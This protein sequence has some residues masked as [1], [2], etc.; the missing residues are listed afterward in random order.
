MASISHDGRGYRRVLFFLPNGDRK[1]VRL[2]KVTAG[3]ADEIRKHVAHLESALVSGGAIN[4][5][6][7]AFFRDDVSEKLAAKFAKHGL[8]NP[9]RAKDGDA[10]GGT[11]GEFL[12]AFLAN[13]TDVKPAT[14]IVWGHTKRNLIDYFGA[15][16]PLRDI[17]P[18]DADDYRTWLMEHAD[19]D[20]TKRLSPA[21]V[22]RRC[23]IAKQFFRAAVRRRKL[24]EN[25]FADVKSGRQANDERDFF[26]TVDMA[27]KILDAC[28][29]GQWRLLFA[30][31]RF[32]GLRCPSEHLALRW[33]DIDWDKGRMTVHSPKTEHHPGGAF[34]IVPLFPQLRPILDAAFLAAKEI[35]EGGSEYVITRYRDASQNLRTTF[36]KIVKRAGF[37]PW[38]KLFANLRASRATELAGQFPGHVAAEWL[39]H[40]EAIARKHYWQVTDADFDR[41]VAGVGDDFEKAAQIAAQT[42]LE[43]S[44]PD[45][46]TVGTQKEKD[47]EFPSLSPSC[48]PVYKC[49]VGGEG[50]E[51]TTSCV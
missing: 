51:P 4:P 6:T 44:G 3:H 25:P 37:K 18:G 33:G 16:K 47:P 23:G 2:G 11:L 29:D 38:P 1:T 41:A 20:E 30:L 46:K 15:D 28:P 39:G 45:G 35:G 48:Q 14:Q 32:G 43:S 13:R 8:P 24:A 42:L 17:T 22:D 5:K 27:A 49:R 7:A 34:R 40:S 12:A 50:L 9:S 26:I 31:S 36:M 21:T 19:G 10:D